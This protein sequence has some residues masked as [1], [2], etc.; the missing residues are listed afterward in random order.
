MEGPQ[1]LYNQSATH[2]ALP[3]YLRGKTE[4]NGALIGELADLFLSTLL[5]PGTRLTALHTKR[6]AMG[7]KL[8]MGEF[9]RRRLA[10]CRH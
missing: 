3:L 10:R 1:T 4:V 6:P 5:F 9:S 7:A 8:N 2:F